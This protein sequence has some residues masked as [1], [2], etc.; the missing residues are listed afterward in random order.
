MV[1]VQKLPFFSTF[2]L[3]NIGKENAFYNILERKNS[4]LG[5]K[6]TSS[7]RQEIDIFSNGLTDGFCPKM[8]NL[9]TWFLRQYR[10]GKCLLQYS[11][12]KERPSRL[13]KQQVKKVEKLT[14]FQT[15]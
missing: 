5:Y 11:R 10:Q 13:Y 6:K 4:C 8:T 9:P 14:F 12:T 3:G 1:L 15:G 7:K 2:F